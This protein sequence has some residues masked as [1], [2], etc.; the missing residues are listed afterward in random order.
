MISVQSEIEKSMRVQS[1][2]IRTDSPLILA[3][4]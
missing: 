2:S 4:V 1:L 3:Q